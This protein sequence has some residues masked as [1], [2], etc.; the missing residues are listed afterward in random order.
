M[1]TG[2]ST[3]DLA[4]ILVD[5]R[6]G[7]LTQTCRH[8]HHRVAAGHPARRAG[9]QQDGSGRL[10]R[11][12]LRRDRGRLLA[13]LAERLGFAAVTAIPISA[14]LRRQCDPAAAPRCPGI[15]GPTLLDH[16]ESVD[17]D[18]ERDAAVPSAGAVGQSH[19]RRFPRLCRHRA[20][21]QHP[22]GRRDRGA[23]LGRS[24]P[25][26]P[27]RHPGR[28]SCR[29]RRRPGRHPDPRPTRSTSRAATSSPPPTGRRMWPTSSPA[30]WSGCTT[31]PMLPGRSYLLQLGTRRMTATVTELKHRIDVETG[32]PPGDEATGAERDRLRQ[33]SLS[34]GRSPSTLRREPGHRRLHPDRPD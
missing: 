34:T 9:G 28:R 24:Q 12:A 7:L 23:A 30:T 13:C 11:A 20:R 33:S 17:V 21:R 19:R 10:Q 15:A 27:H 8:S 26:R 32:C 14:L 5:A 25:R 29:G 16:L 3:A 1:V 4:V 22:A 31:T 6:K 18:R 2:A